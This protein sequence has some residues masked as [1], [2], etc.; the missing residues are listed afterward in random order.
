MSGTG[1]LPEGTHLAYIVW[2]ETWYSREP[3]TRREHPH[4]MVSASTGG[5]GVAWEFTVEEYELGDGKPVTRVKMFYDA[6]AAFAQLP[7]FFSA[8]ADQ[9][10]VTLDEVRYI[11]DSLGAVDETPRVSPYSVTRDECH[12]CQRAG[13]ALQP[14]CDQHPDLMVCSDARECLA[15]IVANTPDPDRAS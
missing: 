9:Q 3:N 8:L 15:F 10:P 1:T 7:E 4:L 13:T 14:C 11:L 5:P 12:H 6:Y 2:D